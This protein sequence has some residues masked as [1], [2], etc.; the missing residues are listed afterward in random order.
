MKQRFAPLA[1]SALLVV[2][3]L[4][5]AACGGETPTPTPPA[6]PPKPV[7]TLAP[8]ASAPAVA[9]QPAGVTAPAGQPTGGAASSAANNG[10][11]GQALT[12]VKS[13]ETYRVDMTISGRGNFTVGV[14]TPEPGAADKDTTLIAMKGEVNGKDSHFVLQGFVT[15]FL[16]MDPSQ[17]LEVTTS[18]D[19]AYI[20]GPVPMLG[21]T[22]AKW[23]ELPA[24]AANM[25]QPPL[26]P[27]SFLQSF[28][29]TGINPA[30][31]KPAGSESL[32]GQ[33]CQVQ[34]GDKNAVVNA[35]N[36]LG[37]A[38]GATQEDLNSIDNAEFKFWVCEDGYLHQVRMVIEGHDKN[39]PNSKGAFSVLMKISDFGSNIKIEPPAGATLL[40]LPPPGATPT[41]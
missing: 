27:S 3:A 14:A 28:G 41:P 1:C 26:T 33:A 21:A 38:T 16:G 29:D 25:A 30:D 24:Q 32:D 5:A 4:T 18:G 17:S 37:G 23:Y 22:E 36:K 39:N 40:T 20:K 8:A 10:P 13:A 12:K 2:I 34:A 9:T 35:F 31:F 7:P 19:K 11:L 15:S 6:A